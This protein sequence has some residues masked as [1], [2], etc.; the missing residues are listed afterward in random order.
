[1]APDEPVTVD[2]PEPEVHVLPAAKKPAPVVAAVKPAQ[3]VEVA[4][5][6]QPERRTL[7]PKWKRQA[8]AGHYAKAVSL[9]EEQGADSALHDVSSDELL[10]FADAARLARR[11]ELGRKALTGLRERFAASAD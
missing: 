7:V 5:P 10:L 2:A 11:P 3:V 8:E 9:V 4:K 6:Q 1:P